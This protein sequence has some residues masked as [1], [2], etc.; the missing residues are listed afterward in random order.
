MHIVVND[1]QYCSE[2]ERIEISPSIFKY[3]NF[4]IDEILEGIVPV[5]LFELIVRYSRSV[6]QLIDDRISDA[7]NGAV[8]N[9][10]QAP[11]S[12]SQE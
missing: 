7:M 3:I 1:V 2:E 5:M 10:P 11:T 9:N 6:R 4:V 12:Y 8:T